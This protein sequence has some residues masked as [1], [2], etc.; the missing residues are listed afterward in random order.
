MHLV[1]QAPVE[2]S[3]TDPSHVQLDH[4]SV[5]ATVPEEAQGF[6]ITTPSAD[7]EDLGTEFNFSV[8]TESVTPPICRVIY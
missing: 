7:V 1:V 5:R 6:L 2:F 3:I 4:G 8:R